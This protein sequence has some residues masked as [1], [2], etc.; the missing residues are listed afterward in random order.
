MNNL[1][2][3][4]KQLVKGYPSVRTLPIHWGEID[5]TGSISSVVL[6]RYF[7]TGRISFFEQI[8]KPHMNADDYVGFLDGK[9]K[10]P[11][12]KTI[13]MNYRNLANY[14]DHIVLATKVD[15]IGKDRFVQHCRMVSLEKEL[16][17]AD[18]E[19]IIVSYDHGKKQKINIPQEWIEAF[20][21]G[22]A[23]G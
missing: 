20:N 11:I 13:T 2:A 19:S 16:V 4:V 17:I 9:G 14:P 21:K 3:A 8:M 1:S 23:S 7:E 5:K 10:G 15:N 6:I 22:S 18:A 12:V